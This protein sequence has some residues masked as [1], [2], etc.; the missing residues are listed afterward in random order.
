MEKL[1]SRPHLPSHIYIWA[2]NEKTSPAIG[3]IFIISVRKTI[4]S[5]LCATRRNLKKSAMP[6]NSSNKNK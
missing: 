2:I 5:S 1:F 6:R 3:G 4:P